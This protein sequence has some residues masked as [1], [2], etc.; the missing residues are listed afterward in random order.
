MT[1]AGFVWGF[2]LL[3]FLQVSDYHFNWFWVCSFTGYG[4][5]H[6]D[7]FSWDLIQRERLRN[8]TRAGKASVSVVIITKHILFLQSLLTFH[9]QCQLQIRSPS[10]PDCSEFAKALPLL[11]LNSKLNGLKEP[12]IK[13][14]LLPSAASPS[15]PSSRNN[16][17]LFVFPFSLCLSKFPF[18]KCPRVTALDPDC[19]V[20]NL[21]ASTLV[22]EPLN[23]YIN[24][25]GL[26]CP[27]CE[28]GSH[29]TVVRV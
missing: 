10:H 23:I 19:L 6:N 11:W 15:L 14:Q 22:V 5:N 8:K 29:M 1:L 13:C 26:S 28:T 7:H 21:I 24:I 18:Q 17:F 12:M 9:A 27:I 25:L 3:F 2:I 4:C 20:G 16:D